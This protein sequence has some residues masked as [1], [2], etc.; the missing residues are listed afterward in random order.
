M[1]SAGPALARA[2]ADVEDD[3]FTWAAAND[4]VRLN[5]KE[6]TPI[7]IKVLE[8]GAAHKQSA[9]AYILGW[10]R[11][12]NSST[13]LRSVAMDPARTVD[14]RAHAIE[15]LGVIAANDALPELLELLSRGEPE[16]RYW[17][18]YSL[19]MIGDPTSIAALEHVAST[20][21]A[22][23]PDNKSIREE[24]LEAIESI[25]RANDPKHDGGEVGYE[26][27]P[28]DRERPK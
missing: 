17:A 21:R 11:E 5:A 10:L 12:R 2:L 14:V 9:A 22:I 1:H 28:F 8:T 3:T 26:N 7:L 6:A 15:A 23:L 4:L 24:A 25:R 20:D 18:A 19:G 16:L 27:S 13:L